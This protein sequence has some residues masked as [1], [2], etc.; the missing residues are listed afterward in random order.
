MAHLSSSIKHLEN[1][2][3]ENPIEAIDAFEKS[4]SIKSLPKSSSSSHH[5]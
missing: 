4:L 5:I 2:L 3:E 1:A